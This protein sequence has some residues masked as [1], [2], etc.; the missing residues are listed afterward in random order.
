MLLIDA[1]KDCGNMLASS[2]LTS[3]ARTQRRQ[4]EAVLI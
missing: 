3:D 1:K 4:N 2:S